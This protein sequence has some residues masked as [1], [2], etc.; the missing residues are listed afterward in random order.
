METTQTDSDFSG[1][2]SVVKILEKEEQGNTGFP[3]KDR[4]AWRNRN[5]YEVL[6]H[7][8]LNKFVAFS[9]KVD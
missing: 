7:A 6:T 4:Y 9:R 1:R 5:L 3:E 8:W 2:E